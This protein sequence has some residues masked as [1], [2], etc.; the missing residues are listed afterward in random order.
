MYLK[1]ISFWF[2]VGSSIKLLF[3]T[4]YIEGYF[5]LV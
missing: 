2:Y 5:Y 4:L 3:A 1:L